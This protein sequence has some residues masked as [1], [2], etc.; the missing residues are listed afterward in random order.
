[1]GVKESG[2]SRGASSLMGDIPRGH[3]KAPWLGPRK[4]ERS[5]ALCSWSEW[6]EETSL[7]RQDRSITWAG[8]VNWVSLDRQGQ[9]PR[10]HS[11]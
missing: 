10:W 3:T 8:G 6:R 4:C 2:E 11:W 5:G 1:M 7:H 9:L